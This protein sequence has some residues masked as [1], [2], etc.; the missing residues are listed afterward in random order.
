L[1]RLKV[2]FL[3]AYRKFY[4]YFKIICGSL[5]AWYSF[6]RA[7]F[8]CYVVN[9]SFRADVYVY[10]KFM[11]R[12]CWVRLNVVSFCSTQGYGFIHACSDIIRSVLP[13][14]WS[15]RGRVQFYVLCC[16]EK[17]CSHNSVGLKYTAGEFNAVAYL[18]RCL[19]R[20][21]ILHLLC[22]IFIIIRMNFILIFYFCYWRSD[23]KG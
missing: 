18:Y 6:T 19:F 23:L 4:K 12:I 20:G 22:I 21:A 11:R 16:H 3:I 5:S 7:F 10:Y 2:K 15:K 14:R 13:E 9:L 8:S 1:V 17:Q